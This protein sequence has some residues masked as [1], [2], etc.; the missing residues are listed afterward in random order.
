MLKVGDL[1]S[2]PVPLNIR[3]FRHVVPFPGQHHIV[4]VIQ[5]LPPDEVLLAL[6]EDLG[7][8]PAGTTFHASLGDVVP[9]ELLWTDSQVKLK[10]AMRAQ[11]R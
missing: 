1:V 10:A 5:V 2:A 11:G 8:A 7:S 9:A 4:A 6:L 3:E